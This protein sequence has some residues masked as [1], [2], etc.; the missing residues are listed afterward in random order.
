[1]VNCTGEIT[2]ASDHEK[3][4]Y[5]N[6]YQQSVEPADRRRA[7]AVAQGGGVD[8]HAVLNAGRRQIYRHIAPQ[9]GFATL[10]RLLCYVMLYRKF[11]TYTTQMLPEFGILVQQ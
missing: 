2:G 8:R 9:P 3:F 6:L 11:N 4:K 5:D 7:R 1:M 10:N